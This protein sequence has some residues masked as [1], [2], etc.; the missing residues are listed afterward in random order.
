LTAGFEPALNENTGAEEVARLEG[1]C[2]VANEKDGTTEERPPDAADTPAPKVGA[3][4]LVV[5]ASGADEAV[6]PVA[7]KV[8]IGGDVDVLPALALAAENENIGAFAASPGFGAANA[9]DAEKV[10]AALDD[11]DCSSPSS[12]SSSLLPDDSSPTSSFLSGH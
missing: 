1:G 10:D 8:K 7:G 2:V 6:P 3:N 11:P 9:P 4:A 5:T 12:S